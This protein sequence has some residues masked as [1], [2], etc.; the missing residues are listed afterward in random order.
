MSETLRLWSGRGEPSR[1]RESNAPNRSQV[2][3]LNGETVRAEL[4]Q[5]GY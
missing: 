2:N 4:A 1:R 3:R 5:A